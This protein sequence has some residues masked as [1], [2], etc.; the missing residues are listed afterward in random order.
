MALPRCLRFDGLKMRVPV[1][2]PRPAA[3]QTLGRL[4]A[5]RGD[6]AA[7]K[8]HALAHLDACA[9]GGH[10]TWGARHALGEVAAGLGSHSDGVRLLAAAARA[11]ADIGVVRFPPE[12]QHWAA[13]D[14]RLREALGEET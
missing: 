10:A 13:I 11:R 2:R 9:E 5:A 3:R 1:S 4:A 8:Q 7:A 14:R 6:W 12:E